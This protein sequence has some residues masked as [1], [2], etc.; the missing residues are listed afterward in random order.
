MDN[1]VP[2][3]SEDGEGSIRAGMLHIEPGTEPYRGALHQEARGTGKGQRVEL[4]AP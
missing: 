4:R 2:Q 1:L 3:S